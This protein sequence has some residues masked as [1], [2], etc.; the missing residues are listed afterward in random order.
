MP[1]LTVK[2]ITSAIAALAVINSV[3]ALAQDDRWFRVEL[4]MFANESSVQ[5]VGAAAA[6][7]W[8]VTPSLAYPGASRFLVDPALVARSKAEFGGESL[9]DEYGRQI[10]TIL[11]QPQPVG[12]A[13]DGHSQLEPAA[14]T[15][16]AV[17]VEPVQDSAP[18]PL[19]PVYSEPMPPVA[20]LSLPR[21]FVIL[22]Q[23][24]QE[25]RGKAALMQ[26]GGRY[27]ILFHETW[28]QPV[29]PEESSLPIVLDRSGDSRQWPR[30]QGTIKLF[31][32]RY[33]HLE[34]NLWVNTAGEYL[35]GT[36]QMPAPP[37]GPPSLIIEE[38]ALIDIATA[39]G[40]PAAG[41][42]PGSGAAT[43]IVGEE[44]TGALT[45]TEVDVLPSTDALTGDA[46]VKIGDVVELEDAAAPIYPYRHAVQL[47]Q[48]RRM[49]SSEV[50]YIDHPLLGVIIKI[51]PVTEEELDA[52]AAATQEAS[53]EGPQAP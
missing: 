46:V 32:S 31:L 20:Q 44:F 9:V 12:G 14:G 19:T 24:Y 17:P 52:I 29:A 48:I 38:E 37:F 33:L 15:G 51:T 53:P 34:T 39:M 49:R 2:L 28:V 5:P 27:S 3:A 42:V 45:S 4:L 41:T 36:W 25:F 10:I 18:A 22:P 6:E 13:A 47:Q 26:R 11:T 23:S 8:D 1:K 21:P 16:P 43:A 40:E 35:P 30:M 7:Q 50:H